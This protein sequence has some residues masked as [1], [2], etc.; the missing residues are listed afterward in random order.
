[1]VDR[2]V[3]EALPSDPAAQ[4]FGL[5]AT[6]TGGGSGPSSPAHVFPGIPEASAG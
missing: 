3:A 5:P 1:M 2:G 4:L 6:C